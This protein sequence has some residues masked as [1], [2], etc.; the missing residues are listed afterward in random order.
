MG[1]AYE[2][3]LRRWRSFTRE[4]ECAI[5]MGL[6]KGSAENITAWIQE[7]RAAIVLKH[8]GALGDYWPATILGKLDLRLLSL[9]SGDYRSHSVCMSRGEGLPSNWKVEKALHG[10][11]ARVFLA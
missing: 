3:H 7:C 10:V 9:C 2:H 6:M 11:A 1:G 5:L 4:K 8:T